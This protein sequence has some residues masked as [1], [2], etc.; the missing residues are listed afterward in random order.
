MVV[1]ESSSPTKVGGA[2]AAVSPS[3]PPIAGGKSP[4]SSAGKTTASTAAVAPRRAS[5]GGGDADVVV[6]KEESLA[7]TSARSTGDESNYSSGSDGSVVDQ[8]GQGQ[9]RGRGE[10]ELASRSITIQNKRFYLDVKQNSRGVFIKIAEVLMDGSKSRLALSLTSAREFRNHLTQFN[11]FYAGSQKTNKYNNA[12]K[13]SSSSS[14]GDYGRNSAL[15]SA[16]IYGNGSAKYP[17]IG[18]RRYF[19]D[20]KENRRGKFLQVAEASSRAGMATRNRVVIPAQ[21][22]IEFR[23][24]LSELLSEYW[25]SD[26]ASL[27]RC[28]EGDISAARGKN[29]PQPKSLRV[30]QGKVLYFDSGVNP[31]GNFLRISQVTT[32]FRTSILLPKDSLT[33]VHNMLGDILKEFDAPKEDLFTSSARSRTSTP[34]GGSAARASSNRNA[35]KGVATAASGAVAS[36]PLAKVAEE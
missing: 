13:G 28:D 16:V 15:K 6:I 9:G 27:G 22:M 17:V 29:F 32:R 26:D 1:G 34:K 8:R 33:R 30:H 11:E 4:A 14:E 36:S 25:P 23:N 7:D 3:T 2:A 21:G 12:R 10:D 19:L 18:R 20:L 31:R 35:A 24:H 5:L